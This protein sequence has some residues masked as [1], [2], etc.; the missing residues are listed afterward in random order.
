M[1]RKTSS[2]QAQ[3]FKSLEVHVRAR[4][5]QGIQG[6]LVTLL[7]PVARKEMRFFRSWTDLGAGGALSQEV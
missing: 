5:Q 3:M 6:M 7:D 4:A 1:L 2:E